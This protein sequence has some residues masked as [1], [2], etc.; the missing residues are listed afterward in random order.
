VPLKFTLM[1]FK[2]NEIDFKLMHFIRKATLTKSTI[3]SDNNKI[4]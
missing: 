2:L 4:L 1:I 3:A